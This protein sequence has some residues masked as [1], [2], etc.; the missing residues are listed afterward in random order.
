MSA[1]SGR[2][3]VAQSNL[4]HRITYSVYATSGYTEYPSVLCIPHFVL[5]LPFM[6]TALC[7]TAM[8][9]RLHYH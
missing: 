2:H 1:T 9:S 8:C 6:V 3:G 7:I 5:P 4:P